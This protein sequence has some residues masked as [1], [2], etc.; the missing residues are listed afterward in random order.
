MCGPPVEAMDHDGWR[1]H[2]GSRTIQPNIFFRSTHHPHRHENLKLSDITNTLPSQCAAGTGPLPHKMATRHEDVENQGF[3]SQYDGESY[4]VDI[5]PPSQEISEGGVE[6]HNG[7]D[8][9]MEGVSPAPSSRGHRAQQLRLPLEKMN[10]R[11]PSNHLMDTD[12]AISPHEQPSSFGFPNHLE[13]DAEQTEELDS[14]IVF[15][16]LNGEDLDKESE[17]GYQLSLEE[18]LPGS[19]RRSFG[20]LLKRQSTFAATFAHF[21]ARPSLITPYMRSVLVDWIVDV[22]TALTFHEETLAL[23]TNLVDRAMAVLNIKPCRLQLVGATCLFIASKYEEV[24]LRSCDDFAYMTGD[25]FTVDEIL[26][27]ETIVLSSL[28]FACTTV[29]PFTFLNKLRDADEAMEQV[30]AENIFSDELE[31]F[32]PMLER[33]EDN[34]LSRT[35]ATLL[36]Q[37]TSY[38]CTLAMLHVQSLE[39]CASHLAAASLSLA[40]SSFG[41]SEWPVGLEALLG[42]SQE[43]VAPCVQFL[44]GALEKPFS[45]RLVACYNRFNTPDMGCIASLLQS[46]SQ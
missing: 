33:E 5:I 25:A 19:L 7:G 27:M 45:K 32:F 3:Y 24:Q 46:T 35:D 44:R 15:H 36:R 41:L 28:Q 4:Y 6:S 8:V 43:D 16:E 26:A 2:R 42:C 13:K 1:E 38:V 23:A 12:I 34:Q 22:C 20:N 14:S 21:A 18:I 9:M 31:M 37:A 17:F 30:Y 39:F 40:R 10:C 29:S 11:S